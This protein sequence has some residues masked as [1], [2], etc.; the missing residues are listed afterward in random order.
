MYKD[1]FNLTALPFKNTPDP[2]FFFMGSRYRDTLALMIHSIVSRKGIIC[3]TGPAGSGKTT[4]A[5]ILSKH[6]NKQSLIIP[7]LYPLITPKELITAT[8]RYLGIQDFSDPGLLCIEAI[9]S[10]LLKINQSERNCV[11]IIDEAQLI[12]NDLLKQLLIFSNLE[13]EQYKLL[14]ILLLGQKELAARLNNKNMRQL[15]QRIAVNVSLEPMNKNQIIQYIYHRLNT[16]GGKIEIFTPEALEQIAALSQGLPR[17]INLLCDAALMDAFIHKKNR[18]ST[19]NIQKAG[20]NGPDVPAKNPY[21]EHGLEKSKHISKKDYYFQPKVIEKKQK[22]I[23]I[24]IAAAFIFMIVFFVF[25]NRVV[26][27]EDLK[28]PVRKK[29][30]KH[31]ALR[32]KQN[33]EQNQESDTK[34]I[35]EIREE[36]P[37]ENI[38]YPYSIMLASFRNLK[39]TENAIDIFRKKGLVPFWVK[40]D[41]GKKGVWFGIYTGLFSSISEAEAKI[42]EHGLTGAVIKNTKYAVQIEDNLTQQ[43]LELKTFLLSNQGVSFYTLNTE[44]LDRLYVGAFLTPQGA[45]QQKKEL[46]AMGIKCRVVER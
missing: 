45:D 38:K 25:T 28:E 46:T 32:P 39:N 44:P 2:A 35:P 37:G 1:H 13:T 31:Q 5:A 36:K 40:F 33:Q 30:I 9:K 4:L 42:Q 16:A 7:I 10:E 43:D 22:K 6:L 41:M 12:S 26:K 23:N 27:K 18:V 17:I 8:A 29:I 20:H 34:A 3:I 24:W 19:A 15:M 14:Q 21:P 11:L